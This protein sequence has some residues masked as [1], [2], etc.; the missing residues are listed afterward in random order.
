MGENGVMASLSLSRIM[1]VQLGF[2]LQASKGKSYGGVDSK[3]D[4]YTFLQ[5]STSDSNKP[6]REAATCN[7]IFC[8]RPQFVHYTISVC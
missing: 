6:V 3:L 7:S 8:H 1:H 4:A 5:A 2:G